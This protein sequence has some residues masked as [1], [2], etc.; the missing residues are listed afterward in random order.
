ME[1]TRAY[2]RGTTIYFRL[3]DFGAT[4]YL[5]GASF[6]AGDTVIR[7][8]GASAN[9]TNTPSSAGAGLYSLALTAGEMQGDDVVV[10]IIDQTATKEW[11]DQ[12]VH[13]STRLGPWVEASKG[14]YGFE[15]TNVSSSATTTTFEGLSIFPD[16]TEPPE[17]DAINGRLLLFVSGDLK[18]VQRKVNDY[19]LSSAGSQSVFTVTAV[20]SAPA[21]GDFCIV[22]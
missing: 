19:T 15:I 9:A 3:V 21:S 1:L 6:A 11:E 12:S 8:D 16:S 17:D 5:A 10:E 2:G 20:S 14:I 13:I 18:G 4:D 7:T 22:T